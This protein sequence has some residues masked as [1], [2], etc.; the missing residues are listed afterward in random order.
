SVVDDRPEAG[1]HR[2]GTVGGLMNR[3]ILTC[4]VLLGACDDGIDVREGETD[5]PWTCPS[6]VPEIV[7]APTTAPQPGGEEVPAEAGVWSCNALRSVSV[8]HR[9]EP[10]IEWTSTQLS[11]VGPVPW[12][13]ELDEHGEPL[14]AVL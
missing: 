2:S 10:S 14:Q 7:H 13:D 11:A 9:S 3:M 1:A 5:V 8:E 12:G 6:D 4:L